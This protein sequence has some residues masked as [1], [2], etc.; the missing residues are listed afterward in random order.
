MEREA[1][2]AAVRNMLTEHRFRH[3][4]GVAETAKQLA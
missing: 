3:T 4:L 1:I 2:L